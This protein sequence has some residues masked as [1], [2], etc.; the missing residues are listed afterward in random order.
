[1]QIRRVLFLG[2]ALAGLVFFVLYSHSPI[3]PQEQEETA[4]EVYLTEPIEI[5]TVLEEMGR[6]GIRI[7]MVMREYTAGEQTSTE[8]YSLEQ[9]DWRDV[10]KLRALFWQ[11]H[12][13]MTADVL[14]SV[15]AQSE[16]QN[17]EG[18]EAEAWQTFADGVKASADEFSKID[19]CWETLDCPDVLIVRL[20][21]FGA[22]ETLQ[23]LADESEIV[24]KIEIQ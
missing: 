24:D 3:Y 6:Y 18:S 11:A 12:G 17:L 20:S 1:M 19:G 2:V 7:P 10:Q 14:D 5:G 16:R 15:E 23:R 4:A 9:D 13:G 21:V 8:G 22:E